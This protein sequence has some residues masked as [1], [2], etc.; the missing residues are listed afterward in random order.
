ML[1]S[2]NWLKDYVPHDLS[3]EEVTDT[4]T[5]S[6][7]NLEEI[8]PQG[9]DTAVDLEVTSNRPD[10][11][12]HLG[13][14]R[15]ISALF[16]QEFKLP[17]AEPTESG[18][19]TGK[20]TS[21]ENLATDLCPRYIARLIRGIKVGPSPEWLK[22]RLAAIGQPSVNN[23]VDVTNYVLMEC[24]QPLHAF[25]LD[26]LAGK[27]I[28]VRRAEQGESIKAID[29]KEYKL[30]AGTCVIA[31]AKN[32]VAI[33]GVM[34]GFATEISDE[35]TN[36]LIETAAFQPLSVRNTARQLNLHSPS[37]Y[38]FERGVDLEQ[39]DW[40]SRRCCELILQ[41]AGGELLPDAI[42]AGDET[43]AENRPIEIRYPQIERV[44]GISIEAGQA[45]QILISL[46]LEKVSSHGETAS[47]LA[48]SWRRDL[49]REIDLIEELARVHG[50]E[51][52]PTNAPISVIPSS[53]SLADRAADRIRETL[54]AN[55]LYEAITMSFVSREMYSLWQSRPKRFEPLTVEHSSRRQENVLRQSLI[56]SLLQWRRENEKHSVFDACLF[57][58]AKV[59]L[60]ADKS[61]P[62]ADA[63]P[64]MLGIV[65]G[66]SFR[67]LKGILESLVYRFNATVRLK[68]EPVTLPQFVEGRAASLSLD[69]RPWGI[70]GELNRDLQDSFD[71][72]DAA[73][74][75]EVQISV[76]EEIADL[77][78]SSRALP[79]YPAIE[80]DLN[81]ILEERTTWQELEQTVRGAAGTLLD[82]VIFRDQYRGKPIAA[83]RKSY[84]LTFSYRSPDRTLVGSEVDAIQQQV[85][86]ACRSRLG[87]ELR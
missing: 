55:G 11:L 85:I 67:E 20:V 74:A 25:D 78:P 80:R 66:W 34:G 46:G 15:E 26:K 63:E 8:V 73:S 38:R 49:V 40:A 7:L 64:R 30:E 71:L 75:A 57:E 65:G 61:L 48:P 82:S 22:E 32:P 83:D 10:C 27:R 5:M 35:T 12:G 45:E 56:P 54:T 87:A 37:S 72:R 59:Y 3:V 53:K 76:L 29:Q 44:L 36:V 77:T 33:A 47:Y 84:V 2:W 86:S 68:V 21:V 9:E 58:L 41:V 1:V 13:V 42:V 52:I 69:G 50:Y 81:F 28:V 24:G 18:P 43:P 60:S 79:Q 4:L 23:V 19:S 6:G 16:R 70:C 39:L 31:D 14:A 17:A 62:E 51:K